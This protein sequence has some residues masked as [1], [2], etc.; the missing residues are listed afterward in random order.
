MP[1]CAH[2]ALAGG[3][4]EGAEDDPDRRPVLSRLRHVPRRPARVAAGA[5]GAPA[6]PA[7]AT[8]RR[9]RCAWRGSRG[10]L[11]RAGSRS[12]AGCALLAA[13]ICTCS[14]GAAHAGWLPMRRVSVVGIC[15]LYSLDSD[16]HRPHNPPSHPACL[17]Y[18]HAACQ[19]SIRLHGRHQT[20]RPSANAPH[21][22]RVRAARR[23]TA[24]SRRCSSGWRPWRRASCPWS[25]CAPARW[26]WPYTATTGAARWA[27][28]GPRVLHTD[29]EQSQAGDHTGDLT[30]VAVLVGV[31]ERLA[32]SGT[33]RALARAGARPGAV[34][35]VPSLHESPGRSCRLQG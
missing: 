22:E 1:H 4:R 33:Q 11:Q 30:A 8:A 25:R 6:P 7:R 18:G 29:S 20:G 9:R 32:G 21:P 26:S 13:R 17:L 35:A 15:W 12:A 16:V 28:A 3:Q 24:R 5:A 2:G 14:T 10:T 34:C 27:P 31:A 19:A 23:R